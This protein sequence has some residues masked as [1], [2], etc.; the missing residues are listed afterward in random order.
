MFTVFLGRRHLCGGGFAG[1]MR[2]GAD[3]GWGAG[4]STGDA[5]APLFPRQE[6]ACST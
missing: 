1:R 5:G 4:N 2:R 3:P 6:G